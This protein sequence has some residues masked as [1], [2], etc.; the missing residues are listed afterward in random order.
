MKNR[1]KIW[2][3][4]SAQFQKTHPLKTLSSL[5]QMPGITAETAKF[6]KWKSAYYLLFRD[7]ERIFFRYFLKHPLKY[8]YR[9]I[10]SALRKKAHLRDGDFFLYGVESVA[11]FKE[12]LQEKE[13]L[14][15]IGFSYC[16][17]P[18]ECP[19]GRF[20][21]QCLH[22]PEHAVCRQCFIGKIRYLLPKQEHI[23]TLVIPTVH[24]IGEQLFI[25][26]QA[27]PEKKIVYLITACELTLEMFGD[28]GTILDGVGIGVRLDGR[29]CNTLRAFELSE[30]G[31]KPGLT[32]VLPS[33]Q[34]RML[35]IIQSLST[36]E[37][38][39]DAPSSHK[40]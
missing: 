2:D 22:D 34:E 30:E 27:N 36:C 35:D 26:S 11:A 13:T 23:V 38:V 16:H 1:L 7:K 31:T 18:F 6:L 29:I 21:D 12:A 20:S 3:E 14:F 8:T 9:W 25:L 32:V 39:L 33:T 10:R 40:A 15:V 19:S 4:K 5:P 28:V 17:K 24:Y 37:R